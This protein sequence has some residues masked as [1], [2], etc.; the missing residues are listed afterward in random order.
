VI[1]ENL[2][3]YRGWRYAWWA[4]GL[5]SA[6]AALYLTQ[7][8]PNQAGGGT[9]QGYVLGTVGALLIVWLALLGVRKR[10]YRSTLGSVQGWTSA[11]VWIGLALVFVATLHCAGQFHWNIHTLTYLLMCVVVASGIFGVYSYLSTPARI[12]ANSDGR[13]R[14]AL[15]AELFE[16]DKRGR[17]LAGGCEPAIDAAVKS[18]IERTALGG[19]VVSQLFGLDRSFYMRSEVADA[20][21]AV[22]LLP[23]QD[24][25]AVIHHVAQR[26]PQ[27]SKRAEA[28]ALQSLVV[29]LC[30]RQTVIRQIRRDIQLQAWLQVWLYAHVPLTFALIAALIV[31]ILITF[32][33][34]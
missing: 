23:N 8:G 17:E 7:S 4:A 15:F 31:H 25:K 3:R 6:C 26:I 27:T 2:L 19:G 21:G 16:L 29:L 34:W 33:Y 9:W 20:A 5:A 18:S 30:R 1:Y 10:R 12:A 11:H 28:V 32:A 24:Q 13:S 14:A 22:G